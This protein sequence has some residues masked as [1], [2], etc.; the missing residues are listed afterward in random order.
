MAIWFHLDKELY[1]ANRKW[2]LDLSRHR[3][4]MIFVSVQNGVSV[5]AQQVQWFSIQ[6]RLRMQRIVFCHGTSMDTWM[7]PQG[8]CC[9]HTWTTKH[10]IVPHWEAS[11]FIP[12][13]KRHVCVRAWNQVG[14]HL[15]HMPEL[16]W[17]NRRH[18]DAI[19]WGYMTWTWKAKWHIG[20][21]RK[22]F[23]IV[24]WWQPTRDAGKRL[25]SFIHLQSQMWAL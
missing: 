13:Q 14:R 3:V 15:S 1:R 4:V 2:Q 11:L 25:F 9:T 24:H 10:E 12:F 18:R 5:Q 20:R 21:R 8:N 19:S 22:A 23:W 17:G 16:P 6:I 7:A